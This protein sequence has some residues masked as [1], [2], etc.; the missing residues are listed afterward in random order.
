MAQEGF[1]RKLTAILSADVVGYIRLI[2]D[3]EEATARG[4]AAHRVLIAGIVQQHRGRIVTAEIYHF[5]SHIFVIISPK[6][7][8]LDL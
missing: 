2:R 7:G 8:D 6:K 5:V 3:D 4:L 1:K